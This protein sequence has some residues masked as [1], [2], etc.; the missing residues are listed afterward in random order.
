MKS[1]LR[2]A[3]FV[4]LSLATVSSTMAEECRHG[5]RGHRRGKSYASQGGYPQAYGSKSYRS[6]SDNGYKYCFGQCKRYHPRPWHCNY[7]HTEYGAPV[8]L[9]LPPTAELTTNMGWGVS[10][11]RVTK[12]CHQFA[13]PYPGPEAAYGNAFLPTPHWPSDTTQFGVYPVRAPWK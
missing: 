7:Y 4:A 13:R 3:L 8:A 9:V 5:K 10:N 2:T 12:V 11:T 6:S 1:I